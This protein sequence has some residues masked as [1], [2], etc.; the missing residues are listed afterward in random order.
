MNTYQ[1]NK[2]YRKRKLSRAI[3]K[4]LNNEWFCMFACLILSFAFGTSIAL[5]L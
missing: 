4:L 5:S 2:A 3:N 1:R